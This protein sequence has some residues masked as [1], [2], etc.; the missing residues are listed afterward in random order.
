ML[1]NGDEYRGSLEKGVPSGHGKLFGKDRVEVYEGEFVDGVKHGNG[2]QT[3][4]NGDIYG[5]MCL[6]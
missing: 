2:K 5:I 3:M 1:P 6:G 4:P